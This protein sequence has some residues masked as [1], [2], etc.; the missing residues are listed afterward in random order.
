MAAPPTAQIR[1]G[2]RGLDVA[3][4]RRVEIFAQPAEFFALPLQL[5]RQQEYQLPDLVL[6]SHSLLH[7][8]TCMEN[9]AVIPAAERIADLVQRRLRMPA[10]QVHGYL[11]RERDV[12]WTSLTGH[13]R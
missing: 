8:L 10:G 12:G 6:A 1:R 11:P 13:I 2:N 3:R 5:A 9:R 4:S 7:G